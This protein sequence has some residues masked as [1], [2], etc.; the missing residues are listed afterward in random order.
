M[1]PYIPTHVYCNIHVFSDYGEDADGVYYPTSDKYADQRRV[2]QDLGQG[3]LD[4]AWAG[5]NATLF[6]YGQTGAGK[7]YSVVG[8]FRYILRC[9]VNTP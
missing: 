9:S 8:M 6:A 4:N 3:V 1:Y 2:F 7:S 5:Y